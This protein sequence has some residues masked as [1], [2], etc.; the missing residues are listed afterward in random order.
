MFLWICL[1]SSSRRVMLSVRLAGDGGGGGSSGAGGGMGGGS[2]GGITH[3]QMVES[4]TTA[5]A[6][7]VPLTSRT[8]AAAT[9]GEATARMPVCDEVRMSSRGASTVM[10]SSSRHSSS[11]PS[12]A[13]C[14]PASTVLRFHA[15]RS[16]SPSGSSPAGSSSVEYSRSVHWAVHAAKVGVGAGVGVGVGP[17][18]SLHGSSA[19]RCHST[20]VYGPDLCTLHPGHAG[21]ETLESTLVFTPALLLTPLVSRAGQAASVR[22]A[23]WVACSESCAAARRLGVVTGSLRE[24]GMSERSSSTSETLLCSVVGSPRSS[25]A[26]IIWM[27]AAAVMSSFDASAPA[28]TKVEWTARATYPGGKGL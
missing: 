28:S 2:S 26:V 8:I 21:A 27:S 23:R 25:A 16:A 11:T 6:A 5:A 3:G 22:A 4:A 7:C 17:V 20:A 10:S 15:P 14:S 19:Q 18:V 13:C 1:I 9:S 24:V 12:S